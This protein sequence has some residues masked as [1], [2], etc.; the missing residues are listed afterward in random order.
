MKMVSSD[1]YRQELSAQLGRAAALGMSR[2][3][4]NARELHSSLGDFPAAND[5][6][7]SCR[8]AMRAEMNADDLLLVSED[9]GA[10]LT[11]RYLLPRKAH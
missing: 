2:I 5:R 8:F 4:I 6:L 3:L 7:V 9:Y 10:D 1:H 11:V